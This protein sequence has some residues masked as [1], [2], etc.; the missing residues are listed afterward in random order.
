V[1][2]DGK[3]LLMQD[4]DNTELFELGARTP[5]RVALAKH[6]SFA[7]EYRC[8]KGDIAYR[9]FEKDKEIGETDLSPE[10]EAEINRELKEI[11]DHP[12]RIRTV[13]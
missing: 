1:W 8:A 10:E 6:D 4:M 9:V 3:R 11:E 2:T 13:K 7:D 5:K 12:E